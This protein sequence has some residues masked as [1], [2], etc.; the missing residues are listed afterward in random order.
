M[1]QTRRIFLLF[2]PDYTILDPL[3][4]SLSRWCRLFICAFLFV[5]KFI[6]GLKYESWSSAHLIIYTSPM[7]TLNGWSNFLCI[8]TQSFDLFTIILL[9]E[10]YACGYVYVQRDEIPSSRWTNNE[11]ICYLYSRRNGIRNKT[12]DE[13]SL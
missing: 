11:W 13:I 3:S 5:I 4:L 6:I 2:S 10:A 12:E 9:R 7:S 8:L 1:I